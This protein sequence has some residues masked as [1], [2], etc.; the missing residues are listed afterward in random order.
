M[1]I[2]EKIKGYLKLD[3]IK[4]SLFVVIVLSFL[5]SEIIF[6]KLDVGFGM[7]L[8]AIAVFSFYAGFRLPYA[9]EDFSSDIAISF[10]V[11]SAYFFIIGLIITA[12]YKFGI[13]LSFGFL[14]LL[15][16]I[17]AVFA[18][19]ILGLFFSILTVIIAFIFSFL[20][21][22][23]GYSSIKIDKESVS[24]GIIDKM[25]NPLFG[26]GISSINPSEG[27]SPGITS[28]IGTMVLGYLLFSFPGLFN[29]TGVLLVCIVIVTLINT[30]VWLKGKLKTKADCRNVFFVSG[31]FSTGLFVLTEI[32]SSILF[33]NQTTFLT[34]PVSLLLVPVVILLITMVGVEN[35]VRKLG[36]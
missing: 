16:P 31:S 32:F 18:M 21:Y 24:Y 30:T 26:G 9:K 35:F 33:E 15:F 29:Y 5:L 4:L 13:D 20:G 27:I 10:G 12:I 7:G 17:V 22:S 14:G 23:F 19:L 36:C 2:I 3:R 25:L 28:F 6:Q 1:V 11:L 34:N 8:F